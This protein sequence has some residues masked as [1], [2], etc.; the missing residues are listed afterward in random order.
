M[1]GMQRPILF[2]DLAGTL[3]VRDP[4]TGRWGLWPGA[5][6][7]LAH[8]GDDFELHL[9]TGDGPGG[10]ASSLQE[11]DLRE[12][13]TG[14]HA[15]LPGGGKPFGQLAAS[16]GRLPEQCLAI[17]DSAQND[18][19]GDSDRLVSVILEHGERLVPPARLQSVVRELAVAEDFLTGFIEALAAAAAAGT[20]DS[21][22]G[23]TLHESTLG[24]GCRLGWWRKTTT[25]E[26]AV[27]LL[28]R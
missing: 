17:G 2:F 5:D 28:S 11:L 13:F 26:R 6:R 10:A 24:G 16:L 19:A 1:S 27:V 25:A 18:T 14:I 15:G 23:N 21:P 9:T 3:E 22:F 4:G 12:F 7:V 20:S 8:L